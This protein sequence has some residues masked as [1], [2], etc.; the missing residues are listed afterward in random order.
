M[1][2]P[3]IKVPKSTVIDKILNMIKNPVWKLENLTSEKAIS[4]DLV[5]DMVRMI[6]L[7]ELLRFLEQYSKYGIHVNEDYNSEL[8][9]ICSRYGF[10]DPDFDVFQFLEDSWRNLD[11]LT[12]ANGEESLV[13]GDEGKKKLDA[14]LRFYPKYWLL[15]KCQMDVPRGKV[16]FDEWAEKT[17]EAF[18]DA[19]IQGRFSWNIQ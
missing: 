5:Q 8:L 11:D 4:L 3:L 18:Q 2:K 1:K 17:K 15:K 10:E 19:G 13:I 6:F 14:L 9:E 16:Q 12:E 7:R